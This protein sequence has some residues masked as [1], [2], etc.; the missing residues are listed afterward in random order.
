MSTMSIKEGKAAQHMSE[1]TTTKLQDLVYS[2]KN[3]VEHHREAASKVNDTI[4]ASVFMELAKER[5]DIMQTIGGFITLADE[6]PDESSSFLGKIKT[7]WTSFRASLNGGDET[8]VLIEAERAEDT[9]MA[10]FKDVLPEIAGN[11]IND[12]LL[13]YFDKVKA[14]HDRILAMRNSYQA[15]S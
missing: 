15:K 13:E 3:S 9:L 8:V 1:E 5:E 2:L 4:V 6:T 11:P 14:G 12:K 7:C 10:Q